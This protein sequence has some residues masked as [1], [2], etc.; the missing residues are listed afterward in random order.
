MSKPQMTI[1]AGELY[2]I[3]KYG[4]IA[5]GV[6]DVIGSSVEEDYEL[7]IMLVNYKIAKDSLVRGLSVREEGGDVSSD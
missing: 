5:E 1:D 4:D 2:Q 6:W 3:E 7:H